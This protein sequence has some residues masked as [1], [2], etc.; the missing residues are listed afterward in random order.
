MKIPICLCVISR[1]VY[2]CALTPA[3][4]MSESVLVNASRLAWMHPPGL[5][6]S[7]VLTGRLVTL[8]SARHYDDSTHKGSSLTFA[9]CL[10]A[11]E[12]LWS[13]AARLRRGFDQRADSSWRR[14]LAAEPVPRGHAA[15]QADSQRP[16]GGSQVRSAALGA[17]RAQLPVLV[18][19][20]SDWKSPS[21]HSCPVHKFT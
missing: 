10:L 3:F 16:V 20:L 15:A 1:A 17:P 14:A 21:I 7:R 19:L 6:N 13:P 2:C 9:V 12:Q 4:G 18:Q 5:S 11:V 8:D